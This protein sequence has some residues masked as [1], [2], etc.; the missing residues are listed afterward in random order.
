MYGQPRTPFVRLAATASESSA[1]VALDR[2]PEGWQAGD[3]LVVVSS[4]HDINCTML[5]NDACET[6][7]VTISSIDGSTVS[8]SSS[9]RYNHTVQTVHADGRSV[10][11]SCEVIN[12]NRNVQI[13]G[14]SGVG[15]A[16]FGGH[17]MLLQPTEGE[18]AFHHV[19]FYRM[20]QAMRV[21][22][23]PLHIHSVTEEGGVG[24]VGNTTVVGVSVH[25]S[26]N[27]GINIHGG[28]GAT[29]NGSTI[30]KNLGH[31]FFV[32]DGSE[33]RNVFVGN[34]GS[35]T[36]RAMSLLESDQT[37]ST[38]W[39]TNANNFFEDNVAA[40]GDA[41]GF[42][43][44]LP[45]HPGGFLSFSGATFRDD[46]FPRHAMLGSFE[47]NTA[48]GYRVGFLAHDLDPKVFDK[49]RQVRRKQDGWSKQWFKEVDD[50][51]GLRRSATF[52]HLLAYSNSEAGAIVADMGH[53]RIIDFGGARRRW[54]AVGAA[55]VALQGGAVGDGVAQGACGLSG[56]RSSFLTVAN[57]SFHGFAAGSAAICACKICD[58]HKGGQE[59]RT[60]SLRFSSMGEGSRLQFMHHFEAIFHDLDGSLT[61]VPGGWM[62]G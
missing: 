29:V 34:L 40:G 26:F 9:L 37:P 35:L 22:R 3:R 2:A 56:P 33:T 54:A 52:R 11:L 48:H 23:Y 42:W 28:S 51:P 4:K 38:F 45:R 36:L 32:E 25:H 59:V 24:D 50:T 31:A 41:F 58:G 21:G 8:L 14:S 15:T 62:H 60:T 44:N 49:R 39:I 43:I 5:R 10:V 1:S 6:E 61:G 16:G 53:L 57:T 12:L 20:G 18:S 46:I 19:E 27:R 30:Y 55:D 13:R 17:V 47:R 7:E